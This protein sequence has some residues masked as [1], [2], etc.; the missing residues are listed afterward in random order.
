GN[1]LCK[2]VQ[3][4]KFVF[5]YVFVFCLLCVTG[6]HLVLSTDEQVRRFEK[7]GPITPEVDVDSL[8]RAKIHTGYYRV[9]PGDIL[10]LQMP[11]VLRVVSAGISKWFEPVY[12]HKY[13]EPYS[14]RVSDA[15]TITLPIVGKMSVAGKKPTEI[16]SSIV[17][18]YYPKYVEN[19]PSVVC[20]VKEYQT[21]NVTVIGGVASPGIYR[22]RSDEMSL[23]AA[24]MKAGGI[25]EDGAGLITIRHSADSDEDELSETTGTP[26]PNVP[27]HPVDT[28]SSDIQQELMLQA[29]SSNVEPYESYPD[30]SEPKESVNSIEVKRPNSKLIVLP[31]KELNIPFADV[32]LH[33]G[34]VVEVEKLDPEVF[35]VLGPVMHP[36]VFPYPPDV[37]YNLTQ[38]LAFAGGPDLT[39]DPRYVTVYR[40]DASGEIVS[41]TFGF[42]KKSLAKA[43]NI[44]IKPGDVISVEMTLD[45][46]AKMILKEMFYIRVGYDLDELIR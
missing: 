33:D 37:Q 16:E 10:E 28:Q 24:L 5:A 11:A 3:Q 30:N 41:A 7:A 32:A 36:G 15:G 19:I 44:K 2:S 26:E 18:A 12:G 23:V 17:N 43:S 29:E 39:L 8:L 21:E 14:F 27:A 46:R 40:Q 6:C 45:M 9:V 25:V 31:V 38:A 35:T 34:D 4:W 1:K 13:I 42:D 22:L 20:K